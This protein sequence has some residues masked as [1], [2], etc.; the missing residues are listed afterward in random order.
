MRILHAFTSLLRAH[1]LHGP[2]PAGDCQ[3][4]I[5]RRPNCAIT[6][7]KSAGEQLDARAVQYAPG[8]GKR[9]EPPDLAINLYSVVIPINLR[10]CFVDLGRISNARFWLR[11]WGQII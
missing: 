9:G 4:I 11:Y 10:L 6:G 2:L 1:D 7:R 3:R 8:P 5:E